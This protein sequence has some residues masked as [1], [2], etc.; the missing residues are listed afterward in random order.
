MG[1]TAA[2]KKPQQTTEN[3]ALTSTGVGKSGEMSSRRPRVG[4]E[5]RQQVM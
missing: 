5:S 3:G 1:A 4:D 2:G